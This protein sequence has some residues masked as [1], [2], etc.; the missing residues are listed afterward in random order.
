MMLKSVS[1]IEL[2]GTDSHAEGCGIE[3]VAGGTRARVAF[4]FRALMLPGGYFLNAGCMGK[5]A[6]GSGFLHRIVDA[7]MLKIESAQSNR[8]HAGFFDT[9]GER[10][11]AWDISTL[12]DFQA[13]AD[14]VSELLGE[15][16]RS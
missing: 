14:P 4:R 2:Y 11:C 13:K 9:S 10:P 5:T 8:R 12:D 6:N 7:V 3:K 1:G 16:A 15:F